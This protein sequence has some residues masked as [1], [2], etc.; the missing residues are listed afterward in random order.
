VTSLVRSVS[1]ESFYAF[2]FLFVRE[3]VMVASTNYVLRSLSFLHLVRTRG[4]LIATRGPLAR[5]R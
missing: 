2:P 1:H 5:S 4:L 3:M